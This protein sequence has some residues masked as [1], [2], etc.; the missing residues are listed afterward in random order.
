MAERVD[1]ACGQVI[2]I[3]SIF[4]ERVRQAASRL[5]DFFGD[6][7]FGSIGRDDFRAYVEK[8]AEWSPGTDKRPI[9]NPAEVG[10]FDIHILGTIAGFAGEIALWELIQTWLEESPVAMAKVLP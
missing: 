9:G 7:R 2:G 4:P 3:P 1:R 5:K 8:C 6:R 10:R